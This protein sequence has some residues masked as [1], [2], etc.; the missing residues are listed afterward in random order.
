MTVS[1]Q[2][3]AWTRFRERVR[4]C[5]IAEGWTQGDLAARLEAAMPAVTNFTVA[6]IESGRRAVTLAEADAIARALGVALGALVD[7]D[8]EQAS[9]ARQ[10]E[11]RL[12]VAVRQ[13]DEARAAFDLAAADLQNAREEVAL[14]LLW[15]W[16][17]CATEVPGAVTHPDDRAAL[18][19]RLATATSDERHIDLIGTPVPPRPSK[20]GG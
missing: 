14:E 5:R 12:S 11:R 16:P 13:L 19:E 3:D 8:G 15:G 20:Q 1:G 6:K 18:S 17:F 2:V 9:T 4:A 7:D 10:H